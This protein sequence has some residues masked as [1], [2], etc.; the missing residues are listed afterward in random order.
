MRPPRWWALGLSLLSFCHLGTRPAS[1]GAEAPA[2]ER[3]VV[4]GLC[5]ALPSHCLHGVLLPTADDLW[6]RAG[7][8]LEPAASAPPEDP[9]GSTCRYLGFQAE[10]LAS[11][12]D[13][14]LALETVLRAAQRIFARDH[15]W[16]AAVAAALG[17][18]VYHH[19]QRSPAAWRQAMEAACRACR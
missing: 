8:L 13:A 19:P 18:L 4:D 15:P 9:R 16:Y 1:L 7:P 17:P 14:G 5:Q 3:L 10:W 11:K 12:R 2:P 6:I